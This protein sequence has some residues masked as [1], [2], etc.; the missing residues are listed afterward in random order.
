MEFDYSVLMANLDYVLIPRKMKD[1]AK[2]QSLINEGVDTD[3]QDLNS[4]KYGDEDSVMTV[5]DN[6][7]TIYGFKTWYKKF[8]GR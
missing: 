3:L 8:G 4:A 5:C 6:F 2:D 7:I 1:I